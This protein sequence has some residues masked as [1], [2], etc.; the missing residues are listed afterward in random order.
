MPKHALSKGSGYGVT[1][2]LSPNV[3]FVLLGISSA[4]TARRLHKFF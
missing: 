1:L 3:P 2:A 4:P